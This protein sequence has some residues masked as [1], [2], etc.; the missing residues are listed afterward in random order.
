MDDSIFY[1]VKKFLGLEEGY[2]PFDGDILLLINSAFSTL[3]QLGLDCGTKIDTDTTWDDVL[4]ESLYF[5]NVKE[6]IC[7]KTKVAW[8]N[9][10][11][12]FTLDAY[13]EIIRECEWRI[14]AE[15]QLLELGA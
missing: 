4:P 10:Q 2:D 5:E 11:N 7:L 8:D 12:S 3:H 14:M 13:K 1:T 9:P 15:R 6:Y